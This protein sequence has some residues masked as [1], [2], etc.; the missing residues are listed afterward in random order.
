MADRSVADQLRGFGVKGILVQMAERGQILELR[1]EMP[2]C[3]HPNGRDKF[4]SLAT[5]R[6]LFGR[7]R[8]TTTRFSDR[9]VESYV[10]TTFG[11]PISSA[12]SVTTRGGSRSGHCF[13]Q[14]NHW[15]TSPTR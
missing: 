1:C 4:E 14:A 12:I 3:Y 10:P 2:Q 9:P 8:A 7:P 13:L 11:C 6:R 5:E 15:K